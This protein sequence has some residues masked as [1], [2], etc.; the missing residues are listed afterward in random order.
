MKNALAKS[1]TGQNGMWTRNLKSSRGTSFGTCLC[2]VL[3]SVPAPRLPLRCIWSAG[4]RPV[5]PVS[6]SFLVRPDHFEHLPHAQ[7]NA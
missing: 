4:R 3:A 5:S 1:T 2:L 7:H 6:L